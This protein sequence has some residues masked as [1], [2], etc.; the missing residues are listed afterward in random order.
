VDN[1]ISSYIRENEISLE[2]GRLIDS[3]GLVGGGSNAGGSRAWITSGGS[4]S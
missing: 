1:I 2:I 4:S 3:F